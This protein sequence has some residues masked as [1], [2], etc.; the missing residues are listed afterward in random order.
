MKALIPYALLGTIGVGGTLAGSF[1]L[2]DGTHIRGPNK[3]PVAAPH[4][5][6]APGAGS[7]ILSAALERTKLPAR[8]GEAFVRVALEGRRADSTARARV[9][10][11]L[12]ILIDRSGSMAGAKMEDAKAAA[13]A[14]IEALLPG[15]EVAVVLFDSGAQEL[16]SAVIADGA[17]AVRALKDNLRLVTDGG[18]T[19]MRDGIRV[20]ADAALRIHKPGAVN[21][22]MLLSDG[23]PDDA[24]G[25]KDQVQALAQRGV[26][27]TTLG[28]GADYNEDLMAGL[29]DA[30]LGRYH[31]IEKPEQLAGIFAEELKSLAT[32][33]A[34]ET[35]VEVEPLAGVQI[36]EV[37]GFDERSE[38]GRAIIPTGDVYG[39]RTTDILV[40]VRVP[41][42]T[43]AHDLLRARV[44]YSD[45]AEQRR[46][47][48]ERTL[49]AAF[50]M[51][52]D[53]S[54]ASLVPAVAVKAEKWR[55]A[56]TY[57][58]ANEAYNRGDTDGG[59]RM[60]TEQKARLEMQATVL[61]TPELKEEAAS[62]DKFQLDNSTAGATGRGAMSK[63][64]KQKAWSLNKGTG[65]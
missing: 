38:A 32:V 51:S 22:M 12:T 14:A 4:H 30:G 41:A 49:A 56:E 3:P 37:I 48:D 46:I 7:V 64:A 9:P 1:S 58:R 55:T 34:R 21:R 26:T 40:R 17:P 62:L 60:I 13:A 59:N 23:Q 36:L 54:L 18:G 5:T 8:G 25:L 11:A 15:D 20:A 42:H 53:E 27:T 28:L 31:F 10:V 16:G 45:V 29:A 35:V 33:V 57:A 61:A 50:V 19:N 24:T 65:Y 44:T 52:D 47:T 39:G 63:A 2:S 6:P 43:G